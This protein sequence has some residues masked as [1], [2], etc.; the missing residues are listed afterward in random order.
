[1]KLFSL[2]ICL[3]VLFGLLGCGDR[4]P[5]NI[6][7]LSIEGFVRAVEI[8]RSP[9]WTGTD[10]IVI[11]FED[12]RVKFFY[13][14]IPDMVKQGANNKIFYERIHYG[15][16]RFSDKIEGITQYPEPKELSK[17]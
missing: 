15:D 14:S 8:N 9:D 13:G 7:H 1:M 12:G 11:G 5:S 16:A 2:T 6:E 10:I 3:I 17:N 4:P